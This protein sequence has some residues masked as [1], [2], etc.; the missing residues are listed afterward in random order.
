MTKPAKLNL[1]VDRLTEIKPALLSG[2]VTSL[3]LNLALSLSI[4]HIF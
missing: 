1:V 4:P 3:S 2:N